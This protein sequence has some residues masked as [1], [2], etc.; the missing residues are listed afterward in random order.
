[1]PYV[2]NK[3]ADQPVHLCSLISVFVIGCLDIKIPELLYP[4]F[5]NSCQ[6]L[7]LRWHEVWVL[8]GL[9]SS[10]TGFLMTWLKCIYYY[11]IFQYSCSSDTG[12]TIF[13][14]GQ[15]YQCHWAGQPIPIYY[16]KVWL[17]VGNITCPACQEICQVGFIV[18]LK[19]PKNSDVKKWCNC[20]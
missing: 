18:V 5:H 16:S 4:K 13:V 8:P 15:P 9:T 7:Q 19:S 6:F 2:N 3:D 14:M 12:L 20:P 11:T 1:M 10:K 17:H